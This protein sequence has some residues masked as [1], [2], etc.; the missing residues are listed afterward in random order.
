[1]DEFDVVLASNRGPVSFT[2]DE[3]GFGIKRGAGGLS[4]ALHPVARRLG[5]RAVWIATAASPLDREAVAA[6]ENERL[7]ER[8]GYRVLLLDI[9]SD[10]YSD[11]YD[12]VA[13][14]MLWFANHCLW[15]EVQSEPFGPREVDAWSNGYDPVNKLFAETI[16]GNSPTEGLVFLQDYHL[17]TAARHL[18][19]LRPDQPIAHFTHSSFCGPQGLRPLPS[20]IPSEFIEGMLGA[21]LLGFHVR[22]WGE[23]FM[24]CAEEL[25]HD[26]D[27]TEGWVRERERRVWVRSYPIP[28][29]AQN[30]KTRS[31]TPRA[32]D[33]AQR[34]REEL[35]EATTILARA[36][37]IEPSKNIVRG[38]RAFERLVGD[39]AQLLERC[40]FVA[41]LYPSREALPEYRAYAEQIRSCVAEINQR[42]PDSISLY[43]ADDFDR[44]LGALLVYDVLLVN[45][46]MDGMNLVAKEGPAINERDGALVLS[47]GAGSWH[48]LREAAISLEEP[49]DVEATAQALKQAIDLPR[50][51]RSRRAQM[52]RGLVQARQPEDWIGPQIEDLRSI[53]RRAKPMS[54]F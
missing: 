13:N 14:R 6:G 40:R 43:M 42:F 20:P 26:V 25:G 48:E 1:M 27:H 18:R 54:A 49:H 24:Q 9:P 11:Y 41:C 35:G 10:T 39:D 47:R 7:P 30:L 8:L 2:R 44:T 53:A 12:T 21:D 50:E 29:D 23:A 19:A 45:P 4:G 16:A 36:D 17:A 15:K 46:I 38:F 32:R 5:D 51:E 33:W 34:F 3:K 31:A 37:R 22:A 28:V 52:L